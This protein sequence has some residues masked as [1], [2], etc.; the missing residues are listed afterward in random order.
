MTQRS[1]AAAQSTGGQMPDQ[2]RRT[3]EDSTARSQPG[4]V[5]D[6]QEVAA[7]ADETIGP[8]HKG[9]PAATWGR[10]V[11]EVVAERRPLSAFPTPLVTLSG[12]ALEHNTDVLAGW[13]SRHGFELAPHGKTT[14]APQLWQRQLDA[15]AWGITLANIAQL[16][17]ARRFGVRR[18]L[19]ANAVLSSLGL[20]WI[21]GELAAHPDITVATWADSLAAVEIMTT[22]LTDAADPRSRPVDVMVERGGV[23]GRTGARTVEEALAVA[24]AIAASPQL[25]LVGAA[26]YE[27]ALAHGSFAEGVA[28]IR[29]YLGEMV[30]LHEILQQRGLYADESPIVSAGGSAYP[31]VVAE[32]LQ[33]LT[34]GATVLIRSG[35][36]VTHDD[37]Y[38]RHISPWGE[39]PRTDGAPLQ[40]AI[41][42]WVRVS[43]V[44]EPGMA[45]FDAGKRDLP[46]DEGLPEVQ[47]LRSREPGGV[48]TALDDVEVTAVNDQH[49]FLRYDP[50]STPVRVGDELRLGLSH[51]CTTFDKWTL[52][53]VV[54][55]ADASDP[56]VVD[57]I[58]T[59]F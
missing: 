15:G 48:A 11:A 4:A 27:G 13:A 59:F 50:A 18:V 58:Q 1:D 10:S 6:R 46:Y 57:A 56:V 3:T 5:I 2:P 20:R 55:D 23:G 38:Y 54:D 28:T 24:E 40:A 49:G 32:A 45:I 17:V 9:W 42:G 34:N 44:P 53:P 26:G 22:A 43:S 51:P 30:R 14:M 35:A 7:L 41:H 39:S 25:R 12:P 29:G 36:Y 8:E 21:A 52:L 16:A 19:I 31:D 37:G 33:P 47:L